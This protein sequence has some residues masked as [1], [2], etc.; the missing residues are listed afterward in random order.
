MKILDFLRFNK[1][2]ETVKTA[3]PL[4]SEFKPGPICARIIS[5][6]EKY[7]FSTW[8]QDGDSL[9]S[10][11]SLKYKL[12]T[13]EWD[14]YYR[15]DGCPNALSDAELL[16]VSLLVNKQKEDAKILKEKRLLKEYFP[17]LV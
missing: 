1:T 16:F 15:V 3:E 9:Y 13:S 14:Y 4:K 6:L 8:N 17:D 11:L 2:P 10:N 12:R 5:D 7:P